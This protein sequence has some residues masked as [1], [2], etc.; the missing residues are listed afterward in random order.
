[1]ASF[2]I[3][4]RLL[5]FFLNQKTFSYHYFSQNLKGIDKIFFAVEFESS[6]VKVSE[7]SHAESRPDLSQLFFVCVCWEQNKPK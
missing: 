4:S 6:V 2:P 7:I 5:P 1:M 3:F